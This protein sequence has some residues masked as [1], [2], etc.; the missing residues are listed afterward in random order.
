MSTMQTND[1]L[2]DVGGNEKAGIYNFDIPVDIDT[3]QELLI[4]EFPVELNIEPIWSEHI[5]ERLELLLVEYH[6]AELLKQRNLLPSRSVLLSGPPGV[7]KT[8][9]AKWLAKKLDIPL[10]TLNLSSVMSSYLGRTGNN[11]NAVLE[12]AKKQKSV[13]LLDEFDTIAK[14]RDDLSEIGELKR[15][16]NVLLQSV[17]NW[18]TDGLLVAATNHPDLLDPAVWRRFDVVMHFQLPNRTLISEGIRKF[19]GDTEEIDK[20]STILSILCEGKS[21]SD[22]HRLLISVKRKEVLENASVFDVVQQSIAMLS[23][24]LSH[25]KRI[26]IATE[27][28]SKKLASQRKISEILGVSRDTIRTKSRQKGV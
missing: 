3:R 1:I 26:Q 2:R 8:L 20:W 24:E 28:H 13:L 22:I 14:R 10:L 15:L 11:L 9:T 27:L 23:S 16:V 4:E 19:W 5:K 6:K 12:Y 21:F 18:N 17:D 25:E 7:G